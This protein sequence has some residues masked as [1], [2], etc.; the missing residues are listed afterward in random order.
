MIFYGGQDACWVHSSHFGSPPPPYVVGVW[1]RLDICCLGCNQ[2]D[3]YAQFANL[4]E[5]KQMFS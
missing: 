3:S 1:G 4:F 5:A 2:Y